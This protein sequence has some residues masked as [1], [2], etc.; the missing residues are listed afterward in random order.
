MHISS[1]IKTDTNAT[2]NLTSTLHSEKKGKLKENARISQFVKPLFIAIGIMSVTAVLIALAATHVV[3]LT[4]ATVLGVGVSFVLTAYFVYKLA[5][6]VFKHETKESPSTPSN[7]YQTA[8]SKNPTN[9][10]SKTKTLS[11]STVKTETSPANPVRESLETGKNLLIEMRKNNGISPASLPIF[12]YLVVKIF[13]KKSVLFDINAGQPADQTFKGV[14]DRSTLLSTRIFSPRTTNL[15]GARDLGRFMQEAA[16]A[17]IPFKRFFIPVIAPGSIDHAILIAV[18]IDSGDSSKANITV[19]DPFGIS[20]YTRSAEAYA[21]SLKDSF[22][23]P[24][25]S[26]VVNKVKQQ[27]DGTTCGYHQLMNTELLFDVPNI[28]EFVKA[29]KMPKRP[30]QEIKNFIDRHLD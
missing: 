30:T 10:S 1:H 2:T 27:V 7:S 25:T 24:K 14:D 22:N 5:K 19:I 4:V 15:E 8:P 29:G 20:S 18:E 28:Q 6:K 9:T 11:S 21:E 3:S 17:N 23:S 13:Q 12:N 16:Q 26:I